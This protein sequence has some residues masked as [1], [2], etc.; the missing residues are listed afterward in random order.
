MGFKFAFMKKTLL[1]LCQIGIFALAPI[2]SMA[3]DPTPLSVNVQLMATGFSSPV[4][5]Y[6]CNDGRMFV[7]EKDAGDIEILDANWGNVGKFLD[8][9][10]TISTGGERGLLGMAFHPDYQNNGYFYLNYTNTSGNTVIARY[11]VSG[12]ANV[13][14]A[15]SALILLTI[16]QPYGNHNGGHIAFGPD[17]YLYIGMGDGG[18]GNDPVNSGQTGTT[19]LGKMLRID[20]DGSENG[21]NYA[22]PDDNP[23]VNDPEAL[24][25]IWDTGLRNP[26]KFSFDSQTG[27]LWIADVGQNAWEE[28]NYAPAGIG[29]HNYGWRCYEGNEVNPNVSPCNEFG[30][31]VLTFPAFA[32]SQNDF[33]FCSITGGIRYRGSEYPGMFGHY[34][35]S[36][37]CSGRLYSMTQDENQ[38]WN[39]TQI[40]PS[41]TFGIVMFYE[42]DLGQVF[43]AHI[44]NGGIYK[45]IDNCGSYDP[46]IEST[47]NG[48]LSASSSPG[49][50]AVNYWWYKDGLLIDGANAASYAPAET[51]S[52]Y[53]VIENNEG[54]SRESNAIN[55]LVTG[56]V[57]GCT[58]QNAD[59]YNIDAEADDGSCTFSAPV[60]CPG[61]LDG[62]SVVNSADLLALLAAY[63]SVC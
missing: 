32:F 28:I 15:A 48:S 52:Y 45:I 11:S 46:F 3:Q 43:Y 54:C 40:R 21:N 51:G 56:G 6:D 36:D 25:E 61:D 22:I 29:G 59:N 63:G 14:D 37:Y 8:L 33:G 41:P 1:H 58:Y 20:V 60:V 31:G 23:F 10:G 12:N 2:A 55:W 30:P 49:Y 38:N 62:N 19:L 24:D 27:D 34:V 5:V 42:N 50:N 7:L 26:W 18:S 13:A 17:G 35:F 47:G 9:T 57:P 39:P 44:N 53:C 4:G 16:N